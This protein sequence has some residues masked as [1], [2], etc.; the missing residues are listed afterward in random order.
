[1]GEHKTPYKIPWWYWTIRFDFEAH[2]REMYRKSGR[3]RQMS[4]WL[5]M[6]MALSG[7]THIPRLHR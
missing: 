7:A 6:I 1:M 5:G 4:A 2:Y 3:S